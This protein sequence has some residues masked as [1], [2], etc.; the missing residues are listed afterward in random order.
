MYNNRRTIDNTSPEANFMLPYQV[1]QKYHPEPNIQWDLK[2]T[3][4]KSKK[5]NKKIELLVYIAESENPIKTYRGVELLS[6]RTGKLYQSIIV[7]DENE[8][9]EKNFNLD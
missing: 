8:S 5:G 3:G 4:E 9:D 1:I 6:R 2:L 7:E